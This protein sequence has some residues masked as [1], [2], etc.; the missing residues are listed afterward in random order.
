[1][2][3][4]HYITKK[5]RCLEFEEKNIENLLVNLLIVRNQAVYIEELI[6]AAAVF[7]AA[8]AF[9]EALKPFL[10]AGYCFFERNILL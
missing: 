9:V 10:A 8:L 5:S 4:I 2:H 7:A 1:M 6:K 3:Y